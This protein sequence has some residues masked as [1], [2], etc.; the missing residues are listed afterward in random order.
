VV[1]GETFTLA[2]LQRHLD[3]II[4]HWQTD[5]RLNRDVRDILRSLEVEFEQQ[6]A[7]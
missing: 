1:E 3:A 7:K 2:M 5:Y 6:F 4:A